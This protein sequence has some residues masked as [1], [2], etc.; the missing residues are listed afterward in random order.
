[1][2]LFWVKG[3]LFLT[4]GN[5]L[6]CPKV[7]PKEQ[8]YTW[9][10]LYFISRSPRVVTSL[11]SVKKRIS[12]ICEMT[13]CSTFRYVA[14]A[15]KRKLKRPSVRV[16]RSFASTD[17]TWEK[18]VVGFNHKPPESRRTWNHLDYHTPVSNVCHLRPHTQTLFN[19]ID[20]LVVQILGSCGAFSVRIIKDRDGRFI[21]TFR[22]ELFWFFQATTQ[23]NGQI[24]GFKR[25]WFSC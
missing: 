25:I 23:T 14:F 8:T 21:N 2:R 24:E 12:Q 3:V 18:R 5:K 6:I 16:P 4:R 19:W 11:C 17:K 22:K 10:S 13:L 20:S 1:M 9:M 7:G 15:N